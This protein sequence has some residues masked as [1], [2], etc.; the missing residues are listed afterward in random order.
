MNEPE[1]GTIPPVLCGSQTK[2][3]ARIASIGRVNNKVHSATEISLFM[4]NYG[5]ELR[6]RAD[7]RKK[8]KMEKVAE[9]AE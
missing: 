5:K 9:F 8:E 6:M 1:I 2:G 7:I 3:L 4:A